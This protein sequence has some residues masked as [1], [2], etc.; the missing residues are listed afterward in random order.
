MNLYKIIIEHS[1]PKDSHISI[2]CL[3]LAKDDEAV[4]EWLKKGY[5][6]LDQTFISTTYEYREDEVFILYDKDYNEIGKETFKERV[7]RLKGLL[8][9]D[10]EKYEDLYYGKTVYGWKL[11]I[12]DLKHIS[13]FD[14]FKKLKLIFEA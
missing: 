4:Y 9:D 3:L 13:Q 7:I 14:E 8:Y 11:I 2:A 6:D 10:E 5:D 1:A 12:K